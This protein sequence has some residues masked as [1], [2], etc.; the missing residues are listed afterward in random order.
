MPR[1][2]AALQSTLRTRQMDVLREAHHWHD[3]RLCSA[4]RCPAQRTSGA[5]V[6]RSLAFACTRCGDTTGAA[7]AIDAWQRLVERQQSE[8][9]ERGASQRQ[10]QADAPLLS[11]GLKV[12]T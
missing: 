2:I 4:G 1:T 7:Q 9:R 8:E 6:Q 11:P 10:E 3:G 12:S 5:T